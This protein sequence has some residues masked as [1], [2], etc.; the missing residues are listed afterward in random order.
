MRVLGDSFQGI[1]GI[2]GR[3]VLERMHLEYN[4]PIKRFYLKY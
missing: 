4:G 3:D 1:D 2:I